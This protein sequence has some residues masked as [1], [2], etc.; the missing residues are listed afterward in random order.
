MQ[1]ESRIAVG[2][3]GFGRAAAMHFEALR[4]SDVAVAAAVCDA[5]AEA[6]E[7]A[8]AA[9]V[10]A[11]ATLDAMLDAVP[12][13]AAL[14]CTPPDVHA[15]VSRACLA[16]G[17][18]VLCEKPLAPVTRDVFQ[19]LEDAA[20]ARRTLVVASKFRHVPEIE[21]A[22][23]LLAGGT[24]GDP[25]HFTISFCGAVD[26][27]TRWNAEPGR[28]GGGVIMD[29]GSHAFDL[30]A[31]LFGP[32]HRVHATRLRAV[33]PLAV[34]DS[35]VLRVWAGDGVIGTVD[36]S[37]S[38]S[39]LADRYL[40]VACSHGT[41]EVGWQGA[42]LQ[43]NGTPPTALGGAYDRRIAHRA[44]HARFA[45][46]VRERATPWISSFECLQVAAALDAAYR[47]LDS[48]IAE[49]VALR[50]SRLPERV[51]FSRERTAAPALPPAA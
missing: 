6:R 21:R 16:R 41:I 39:L 34:E 37:W 33:Q 17:L 18:H 11:F 26:M 20:R 31:Y 2:L 48:G 10:P 12:L 5:S 15:A 13:D 42:R 23:A 45:A 22:R 44:M 29:N 3:V 40:S 49:S 25:V 30:I 32:I 24:L 46:A 4:D 47:S 14:V 19:M 28:A 7:R 51:S 35:A 36:L 38:V 8:V 27:R 50:D 1:D 9:G 43:C